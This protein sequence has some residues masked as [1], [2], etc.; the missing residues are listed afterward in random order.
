M[1]V[2]TPVKFNSPPVLQIGNDI[3]ENA[4]GDI[5]T[6]DTAGEYLIN[7][8][9]VAYTG[10]PLVTINTDA[11]LTSNNLGVIDSINLNQQHVV[12]QSSVTVNLQ[13]GNQIRLN[14]FENADVGMI[15]I[16]S[17]VITLMKV[18]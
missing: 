9:L 5:F 13:A 3:T 7:Y 18:G 1:Y 10:N 2:L 16:N 15:L 4:D 6:A 12:N 14:V 8:Q 17:P 11:R